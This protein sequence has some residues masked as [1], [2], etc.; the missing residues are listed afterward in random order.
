MAD[1]EYKNG[2]L[3]LNKL[4]IG[5]QY[6]QIEDPEGRSEITTDSEDKIISYRGSDGIQHENIG[7]HTSILSVDDAIIFGT[8]AKDI[9]HNDVESIIKENVTISDIK[10]PK[11][12]LVDIVSE[13]FYLVAAGWSDYSTDVELR[14]DYPDTN[15]NAKNMVTLSN[16][17]IKGTNNKLDF[18]AATKVTKVLDHYYVTSTLTK[19]VDPIT[20]EVTYEVN[21]NSIE[22]RQCI[23][24]PPY[25]AWPVDKK[26]EHNCI[27]NIDFGHY[28]KK[29]DIA[30][31]VKYQGSSTLMQRKRN[32]R[33][34]FYKNTSYSKK[35]KIKI[36]EMVRLSGY[37]LKANFGDQSRI[38]ELLLY[39][40]ILSI[41]EN[42][43]ITERYPWDKT[44]GYYTGAT[45]FIK[46]FDVRTS[47]GGEFYGMQSF[48]LKKDEKNYML[49][50]EDSDGI[51]V[52]GNRRNPGCWTDGSHVDWDEEMLD[53]MSQST[54]DAID[55]FYDYINNRLEDGQGG[56]IEF[57]T[58]TAPERMDVLGFIDYFICLQTFV[59]WD[60]TCRNMVLHTRSDKK[61]FYPFFYD[62]DLCF[63]G[64]QD[65]H[66]DQ[67]DA[68]IFEEAYTMV[69]GQKEYWDMSL[70]ENI[71]DM[72]WDEIVNRWCNLRNS[73][74]TIENV[75]KAYHQLTD[76]IP[77][78]DYN[79]ENT[80]WGSSASKIAGENLL[81][82]IGQRLEWLDI[83]Y[84]KI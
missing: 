1:M 71:R 23:D 7:L 33:F 6:E 35:D 57:N 11:Y 34:T 75:T 31:G 36:G 28:Y 45:G 55:V 39:A 74:L 64:G 78:S 3:C 72:F 61:K 53:D 51:F 63:R 8:K 82:L 47:I 21:E 24:V 29:N 38:K 68:D 4:D 65:Y 41:W 54:A 30:I 84:F 26:T 56:I 67:P 58:D 77:D 20:G 5:V 73:V 2:A 69:D 50:G 16:F 60:N 32:F 80:R 76:Q 25:K 27:V 19:I 70:W 79:D 22:V 10:L 62:L 52:C 15:E 9:F 66:G 13:T 14:Q 18:Y 43:P 46:G 12:G 44:F 37:N 81:T 42:R 17:Y 49:N 59:M 48:A 40:V 83:N